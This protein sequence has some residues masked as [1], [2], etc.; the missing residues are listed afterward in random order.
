MPKRRYLMRG[1]QID[2]GVILLAAFALFLTLAWSYDGKCG[3]FLP[4]LSA[5]A[6][7]SFSHYVFGGMAVYTLILGIEF[8]PF[9]LGALLLPPLIGFLIDRR[10]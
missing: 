1:V 8:W 5:A 3:G 9:V 7:C 10:A 2:L 4:F 6:P